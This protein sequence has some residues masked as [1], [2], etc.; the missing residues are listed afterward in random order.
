MD[1]L[2]SDRS[3]VEISTRVQGIL[4]EYAIDSWQ[5]EPHYQHQNFAERRYSVVKPLM[6]I[7]INFCGALA[8][9]LLLALMYVCLF[10]IIQLLGHYISVL[11][12]ECLLDQLHTSVHSS[13]FTCGNQFNRVDNNDFPSESTE[14][15][16]HFV[17][18]SGYIGHALT[19]KILLMTL[20]GH[21]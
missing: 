20:K 11:I 7:L 1:K 5:S 10:S 9:C 6:N 15:L 16:G 13:A 17:C 2:I 19:F 21:P 4:R 3:Q 8:Y 18:I 12:Y 14:K